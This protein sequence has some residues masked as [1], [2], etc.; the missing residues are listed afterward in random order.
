MTDWLIAGCIYG[1]AVILGRWLAEYIDPFAAGWIVASAA[2]L[3]RTTGPESIRA[4]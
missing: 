4:H 2:V 1:P 3:L